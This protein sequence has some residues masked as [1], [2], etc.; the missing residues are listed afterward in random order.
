VED[1]LPKLG[2]VTV[3][4]GR[5]GAGKTRLAHAILCRESPDRLVVIDTIAEHQSLAPRCPKWR[6]ILRMNPPGTTNPLRLGILPQNEQEFELACGAIWARE[7]LVCLIDELDWWVPTPAHACPDALRSIVRYGRH[8]GQRLI[9][10]ARRPAAMP[11]EITSQADLWIFPAA[12]PRD[13]AYIRQWADFD[14]S[15]LPDGQVAYCRAGQSPL[16]FN[17]DVAALEISPA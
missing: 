7:N 11:R 2:G 5:R 12:E 13:V 1:S 6:A 17:F 3:I 4:L 16:T 9:A 10:I 14:A 15:A 8:Y